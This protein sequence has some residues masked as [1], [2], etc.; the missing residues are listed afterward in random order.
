MRKLGQFSYDLGATQHLM[1]KLD[2]RKVSRPLPQNRECSPHP[3]G[4]D[5]YKWGLA[6]QE[7]LQ[8]DS[9]ES[10]TWTQNSSS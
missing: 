7:S 8:S 5:T 9:K 4:P 10:E 2:P 6:A 3:A 1:T